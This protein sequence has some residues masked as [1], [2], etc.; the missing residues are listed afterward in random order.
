MRLP[1]ATRSTRDVGDRSRRHPER[2]GPRVRG[3]E[4]GDDPL[5]GLLGEIAAG[6][7]VPD[8]QGGTACDSDRRACAVA[9]HTLV[10]S[11]GES[12]L[13]MLLVQRIWRR[14]CG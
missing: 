9:G 7:D 11:C 6:R 8:R 1:G 10:I 5:R 4:A 13:I 2:R 3:F 12:V 14:V